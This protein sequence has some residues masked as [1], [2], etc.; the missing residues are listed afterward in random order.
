[1]KIIPISAYE[2]KDRPWVTRLLR[3]LGYLIVIGCV[4][5]GI[6]TGGKQ[7]GLLLRQ[8]FNL[9]Y[10]GTAVLG[11]VIGGLLGF[12]G[13]LIVSVPYWGLAMLLDDIR[14]IRVQTAGYAATDRD[15]G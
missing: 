13:G 9:D 3:Y 15:I 14:A 6:T 8:L 7:I 11:A 12:V 5:Y 10:N 1:M 4:L 2:P